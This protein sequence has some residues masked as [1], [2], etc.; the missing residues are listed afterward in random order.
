[1][2]IRLP[3][4]L[5]AATCVCRAADTPAQQA[6][7]VLPGVRMET[8]TSFAHLVK[9]RSGRHTLVINYPWKAH[10]QPSVEV[11]LVTGQQ[12]DLAGARP[13]FFAKQYLKG[14]V[15]VN[16][17]HCHDASAGVATSQPLT[18]NEITFEIIG[19]RNSLGKPS[20]CI[21]RHI[22]ND[23]PAPGAAVVYCLL[24]SWSL[25]KGMLNLDLPPEYFA[26]PG[27][28][29][30]WFLRGEKVLWQEVEAWPGYS[31]PQ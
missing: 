11:R 12:A 30:V 3:M 5:I 31:R 22:P 8:D 9:E 28:L 13:L 26:K 29:F 18:K 1:M 10:R 6:E 25:D 14:E 24:P 7:N 23:E 20:V 21:A 4:L 15:T 27:K 2:S 19:R 16:V 17:Y